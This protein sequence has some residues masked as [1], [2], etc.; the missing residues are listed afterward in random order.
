MRFV[1]TTGLTRTQPSPS[2]RTACRRHG[3][4]ATAGRSTVRIPLEATNISLL[5][6]VQTGSGAHPT[7]YSMGTGFISWEQTGGSV[8]LTTD[9]HLVPRLRM[10][11]GI[12]QRP[13]MPPW[14]RHRK[15]HLLLQN[16]KQSHYR[17]GVAQRVP[18]S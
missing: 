7:S 18:G 13:H 8:K 3:D 1:F 5:H 10:S 14:S 17:P 2:S 4:Y 11:G 12:F 16:V 15:L 6:N 9:L